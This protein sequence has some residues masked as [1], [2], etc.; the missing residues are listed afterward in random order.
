MGPCEMKA[1]GEQKCKRVH[2]LKGQCLGCG[3][4]KR[5]EMPVQ[6]L[7]GPQMS[8]PRTFLVSGPPL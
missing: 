6:M 5:G 3:R 1:R 4:G 2:R 7:Y 8:G